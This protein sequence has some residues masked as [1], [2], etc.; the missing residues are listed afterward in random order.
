[1]A[2]LK[3]Q[4]DPVFKARVPISQAGGSDVFVEFT[5]KHRTRE[6]LQAFIDASA[7]RDEQ[8]TILE[9]A[10]GWEL[11]D[12]FTRESLD[13]LVANYISAG[14][15]IFTTYIDELTKTRIKN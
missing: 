11:S 14:H 6:E 13:V 3:L 15:A 7:K 9:A 1:M 4:P 8:D 5:F 12:P 10:T 2:K